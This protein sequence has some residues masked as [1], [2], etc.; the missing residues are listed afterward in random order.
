MGTP[1]RSG[2]CTQS[3]AS[4]HGTP[5]V[6]R[7]EGSTGG[8][9]QRWLDRDKNA[10][11]SCHDQSRGIAVRMTGTGFRERLTRHK[12]AKVQNIAQPRQLSFLHPS[13]SAFCVLSPIRDPARV[14]TAGHGSRGPKPSTGRI[15]PSPSRPRIQTNE[16]LAKGVARRRRFRPD[17]SGALNR[18]NGTAVRHARSSA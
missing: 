7:T 18:T 11:S 5:V 17:V 6:A 8:D 15:R 10:P 13:R 4:R 14:M 2:W 16:R 9:A 12:T 1:T 3:K